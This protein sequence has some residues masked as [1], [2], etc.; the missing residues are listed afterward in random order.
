M[1][2]RPT[3]PRATC[4]DMARMRAMGARFSGGGL[5]MVFRKGCDDFLRCGML[6]PRIPIV[7]SG[8]EIS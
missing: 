3:W 7:T 2:D 4:E 8:A 1:I 5:A 6:I